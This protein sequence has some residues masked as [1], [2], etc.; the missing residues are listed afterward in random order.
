MSISM[1]IIWS[2]ICT[3]IFNGRVYL[4]AVTWYRGSS[5][6]SCTLFQYSAIVVVQR[7][8]ST[9]IL[10]A[11]LYGYWTW[12]SEQSPMESGWNALSTLSPTSGKSCLPVLPGKSSYGGVYT[13]PAQQ[14]LRTRLASSRP[15]L[16]I[17]FTVKKRPRRSTPLLLTRVKLINP[18]EVCCRHDPVLITKIICNVVAASTSLVPRPL[19]AFF[20]CWDPMSCMWHWIPG[21]SFFLACVE[22]IREPGDEALD[23]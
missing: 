13:L 1:G 22:K 23:K 12:I 3:L 20:T 8:K 9:L 4:P 19:S 17:L 5:C 16:A 6:F 15:S 7:G 11:S 21:S 14:Q 10:L 18:P 2:S